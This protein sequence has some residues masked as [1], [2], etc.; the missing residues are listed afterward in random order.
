NVLCSYSLARKSKIFAN[1]EQPQE[2]GDTMDVLSDVLRNVRLSGSLLFFAEYRTPW[3]VTCPPSHMFAHLLVPGARRLVIFHIVID[4]VC[5]VNRPNEK[6]IELR[7]G[8][9]VMMA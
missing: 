8:D 6:P 2:E 1:R 5:L 7:A 9:A 4:G 3:C